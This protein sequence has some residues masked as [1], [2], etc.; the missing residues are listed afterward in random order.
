MAIDSPVTAAIGG[1]P[2]VGHRF[3]RS[4]DR[5]AITATGELRWSTLV[6][7]APPVTPRSV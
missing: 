4:G 6:H 7:V 3:D 5:V 2:C 1:K